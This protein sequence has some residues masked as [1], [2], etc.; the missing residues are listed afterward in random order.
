M[1]AILMDLSNDW[2]DFCYYLCIM[3]KTIRIFIV[4]TALLT[5]AQ[6]FAAAQ[7]TFGNVVSVDKVNHDFGDI[8]TDQGPVS[9][10]YTFKN[11]SNKPILLLQAVS[12]CGCTTTDWTREPIQP[13]KTGTVRAEFDNNDGPYPFDK[14]VTVYV[15]DLKNPIVLHLRGSAHENA[16]PLKE[17]YTL[18]IGNLGIKSLEIKAGTLSQRETKSGT[19]AVANIGR[20]PMKV[21]FKNVSDG[22]RLE[23]FPNPIPARSVA[24]ITYTIQTSRERWGKNWYYATPVV[25]GK[26]Y[27]A[28]GTL[29]KA[30][31]PV[32]DLHFYT[33]SNKRLGIGKSEI[34]FWAITKENFIGISQ[35]QKE[36]MANPTFT[37]STVNFGK[38]SAGVKTKVTFEYT[39]KGKKDC[40]FHK[41]DADCSNVKVLEMEKTAPGKKG[42]IVLELDTAGMPKGDNVI[43]LTLIT[44]S[45]LRPVISLQIAGTI[46]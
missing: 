7:S 33:E 34:G 2:K 30:E 31:E 9:C 42:K 46:Q 20:A 44:N 29:P 25:D 27:K 37:K 14:T 32:E 1:Y 16:K 35:E 13:G 6:G 40:E 26:V 10:T 38:V 36:E 43:A 15:S 5:M 28:T 18:I 22:L 19:V 24:N 4:L 23:V 12:S 39:N 21:E 8:F 11:I 41:L 17:T 45:A 3:K